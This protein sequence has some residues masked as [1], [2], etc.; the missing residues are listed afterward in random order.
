MEFLKFLNHKFNSRS[1][2]WHPLLAVY[3]LSY[4]CNFRCPYC[5]DG[6]QI[7]YYKLPRIKVHPESAISILKR[8]RAHSSYVVITGGEPLLSDNFAEI[9]EK[10]PALNFKKVILT[11]NGFPLENYLQ[12]IA[13]SVHELVISL[14]TLDCQKADRWYGIGTGALDRIL[15]NIDLTASYRSRKFRVVISS[16]VTPENIPDL[17]EVFRYSQLHGFLFAAAPQLMGVKAHPAAGQ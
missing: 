4:D 11:T 3:Y 8:I 12:Q 10:V 16:V 14:D 7:P 9:M 2:R 5:C 17:Y 1:T 13:A 15:T 6:S